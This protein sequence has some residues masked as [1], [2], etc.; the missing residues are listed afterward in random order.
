MRYVDTYGKNTTSST[1]SQPPNN[2]FPFLVPYQ[3]LSPRPSHHEPKSIRTSSFHI[4]PFA[5]TF[6]SIFTLNPLAA[7]LF[8]FHQL[9]TYDWI[10]N[11]FYTQMMCYWNVISK[12]NRTYNAFLKLGSRYRKKI[13]VF[14][15]ENGVRRILR[16]PRIYV[17]NLQIS[18]L[19]V[20]VPEVTS[21]T[22][23]ANRM[24]NSEISPCGGW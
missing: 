3:L 4:H 14:L 17:P 10:A 6:S 16:F 20:T 21:S 7:S 13:G 11:D 19:N 5:T 2:P 24:I 23:G 12:Y 15:Q 1:P 22:S 8:M 18:L 9:K